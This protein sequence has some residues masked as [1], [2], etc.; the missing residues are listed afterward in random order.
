MDAMKQISTAIH[1]AMAEFKKEFGQDAKL[2]NG[3]GFVTI[4][5]NAI[6]V[7][8]VEENSLKTKFIGGKP[9]RVDMALEIYESEAE[10][11]D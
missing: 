9:Y 7:I 4:F 6:L 5:N 8:L 3:D 11:N 2:E 10:K 1:A